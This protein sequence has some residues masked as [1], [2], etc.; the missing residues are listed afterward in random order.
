[1]YFLYQ[2]G[3]II[4]LFNRS[5]GFRNKMWRQ[6]FEINYRLIPIKVAYA[7]F[8]LGKVTACGLH[9]VLYILNEQITSDLK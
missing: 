7:S 3:T 6:F 5:S 2:Y 1:M 9:V 8:A 4:V